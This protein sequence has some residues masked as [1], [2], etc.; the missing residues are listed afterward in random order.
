[1]GGIPEDNKSG[2]L[3]AKFEKFF[4]EEKKKPEK[5]RSLWNVL[6]LTVGYGRLIWALILF[7]VYAG[8]QFG[9]V[10]I[11]TRLV[12]Y[13]QGL[14]YYSKAE[15][16]V[17][18][19]LLFIFPMVGSLAAA[20]SN[21]IMANIGAQVRNTLI[22]IIYR[23]SLVISPYSKQ[24]IGTGRIITMFSDDTNQIRNFLFFVNNAILAP[25]QIGA[26]LYLIYQQVGVAT[27]VGLGYSVVV[28]PITGIVFGIV[29][30]MRKYVCFI[31]LNNRFL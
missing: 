7:G 24:F 14:T 9:P 11:L 4:E 15:L 18:V 12:K 6:W 13:F 27:F 2:V 19:A 8:L 3:Y 28:T 10:L 21:S 30:K 17:M 25:F 20:H 16:W 29:F 1:M 22:N 5:K 23:K 31:Y 26:C